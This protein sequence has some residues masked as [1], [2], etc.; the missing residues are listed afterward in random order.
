MCQNS[1]SFH[2]E[3]FILKL[4]RTMDQR[5]CGLNRPFLSL[6]RCSSRFGVGHQLF[7]REPRLVLIQTNFC[8][9]ESMW[10]LE[11]WSPNL[12]MLDAGRCCV[13]PAFSNQIHVCLGVSWRQLASDFFRLLQDCSSWSWRYHTTRVSL[14]AFGTIY[15][16][17][18][19]DVWIQNICISA[20]PHWSGIWSYHV[21]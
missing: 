7:W 20:F 15:V 16:T 13:K 12:K 10:A 19:L 8:S 11:S 21:T 9:C 4:F 14:T 2:Y 17:R 18:F 1:I 5:K 3:A 6:F